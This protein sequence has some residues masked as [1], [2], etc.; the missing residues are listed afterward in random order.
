MAAR[1]THAVRAVIDLSDTYFY[2]GRLTD[3]VQLP[4]QLLALM[5]E[6]D[7]SAED[8][9]RLLLH[10]GKILGKMSF[11]REVHFERAGEVLSKAQKMARDLGDNYLRG[12]ARLRLGQLTDYQSIYTGIDELQVALNH[13]ERAYELL[14]E[15]GS[16]E[17]QG[18]A[19]FGKGLIYQRL[20]EL[21]QARA[22][23]EEALALAEAHDLKYDKSLAIRHIGF[24]HFAAGDL[25]KACA[26]AQQSLALREEIGCQVLL[27][28][29]HHVLGNVSIAREEWADAI[30]HLQQ[31]DALAQEMDLKFV[32]IMT[33]L[34][35]GEWYKRQ[36]DPEQARENF[37]LAKGIAEETGHVTGRVAA[38]ADIAELAADLA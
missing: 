34:S 5:R 9:T 14:A 12:K 25:D 1:Y 8:E 4:E 17:G 2:A 35:I 31:A 26:S 23:F 29:A 36:N 22:N 30:A 18:K 32:R 7:A 6:G 21:D 27:A 20:G 33:L 24:I 15:A 28:S 11:Y 37:E 38:E 3:A 16:P 10:Y 19:A 13:Y